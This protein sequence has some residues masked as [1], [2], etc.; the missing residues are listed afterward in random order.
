MWQ[1]LT[2]N[3]IV[4][5]QESSNIGPTS[6]FSQ[7][8]QSLESMAQHVAGM[9]EQRPK[10]C[11]VCLETPSQFAHFCTR[12]FNGQVCSDCIKDWF[13]D[14]CKN[15]SK[16][17]PKCCKEIPLASVSKY[18]GPAEVRNISF[19]FSYTRSLYCFRDSRT[20]A[21]ILRERAGESGTLGCNSSKRLGE[22]TSLFEK[23]CTLKLT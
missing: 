14:A 8:Q 3:P 13:M 22:W 5:P 6:L 15:E 7:S 21:F 20:K 1:V 19:H 11:M 10:T 16:M 12:C 9:V 17:P 23:F 2:N 18:L 4:N